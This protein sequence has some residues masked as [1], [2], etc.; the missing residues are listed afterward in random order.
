[1]I[2]NAYSS[3]LSRFGPVRSNSSSLKRWP[4]LTNRLTLCTLVRRSGYSAT[5][6]RA[7]FMIAFCDSVA[8]LSSVRRT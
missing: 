3:S 8:I 2:C 1:M 4:P 5:T 6:A 7:F